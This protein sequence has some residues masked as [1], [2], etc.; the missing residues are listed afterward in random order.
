M[1]KALIMKYKIFFLF[2][3]EVKWKS[4]V[5]NGKYNSGKLQV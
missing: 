3:L 5:L 2:M 1:I 4:L